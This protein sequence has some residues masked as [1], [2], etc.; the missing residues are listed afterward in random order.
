MKR[1]SF[2]VQLALL[3]AAISGV[4]LLA[5]GLVAW[6]SLK[7]Q[8]ISSVDARIE[9]A[10][11]Q[12][13]QIF[14]P[15]KGMENFLEQW[16]GSWEGSLEGAERVV[17]I[18]NRRETGFVLVSPE[19]NWLDKTTLEAYVEPPP[20]DPDRPD[21]TREATG[22]EPPPGG[23]GPGRGGRRGPPPDRGRLPMKSTFFSLTSPEGDEWR[24]VSVVSPH[25]TMV[26]GIRLKDIAHE[27]SPARNLFLA[28]IPFSILAVV[29]GAIFIS[30]RALR[31][32]ARITETAE[33][34]DA[35]ALDARVPLSGAE[36]V[37]FARLADVLNAM[38]VRL[39]TSFDQATRFTADASHELK[40]PIAIIQAEVAAALKSGKL[41][42]AEEEVL[43]G[44]AGEVQR[45][46]RITQSLLLLS[47]ADA[48]QLRLARERVD[49]SEEI[50]SLC[51]DAELICSEESLLFEHDVTPGISVDAD[52]V[53]LRQAA[54]NL[55]TNAVKYNVEGGR[56]HFGLT[57]DGTHAEISLSNTG[58]G[59]PEL[60]RDV[61][62]ERFYR[63]D[64]ARNRK[65][66]GFGLG[67]NLAQEIA[68]AHGGTLTLDPASASEETLTTFVLRIPLAQESVGK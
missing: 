48:G 19:G 40:T 18:L 52:P 35:T 68:R 30:R 67:L 27:I 39:E 28:A 43:S 53:L 33:S 6:V 37:E 56:V 20:V 45:L 5:F 47:Q 21:S 46:K 17:A 11:V 38:M 58:K 57:S 2:Q 36:Y 4:I 12:S 1:R 3:S 25:D 34:I 7:R 32:L 15:G 14:R 10:A 55:L 44:I 60:E 16:N 50:N 51:E 41:G 54:Q 13:F 64:R 59:I 62:F 22:R 63:L 66:D 23:P 29:G 8:F 31:P 49:L 24:M 26:T 61:I 42:L 9:N 65:K